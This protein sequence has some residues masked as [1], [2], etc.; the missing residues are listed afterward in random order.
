MML[1]LTQMLLFFIISLVT[2]FNNRKIIDLTHP[3]GENTFVWPTSTKFT[4]ANVVKTQVG[5]EGEGGYWYESRDINQAEHSG[6][7][8]DAPAHF[9]KGGWH[10][11]DIPLERLTGPGV[12]ISIEE[13][14]QKDLDTG[15]VVEDILT[16]EEQHGE[17]PEGAVVIIHTGHGRWYGD[18]VKYLG[19]PAELDLPEN[20]TEHLHFP[21]VEPAAAEWLVRNRNIVGLGIDTPSTSNGQS[22]DYKTHQV[23]GEANIWGL[24][25]MARTEELP[26][27]GFV[28]YNMV[29]KLE[30][31]SGGPTRVIAI[32]G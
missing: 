15:L 23:L 5:V 2:S 20:D 12:R 14:V 8:M 7:H 21:G 17:V 10:T 13:R 27:T 1:T 31:G 29:H 18:K 26:S 22:R 6:T 28:V 19:R 4:V 11:S 9:Y 25:N 30:G 16:W 24:E 3:V 32:L